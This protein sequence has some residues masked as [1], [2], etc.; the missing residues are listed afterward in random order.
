[1]DIKTKRKA[2]EQG[3]VAR[4]FDDVSK[5]SLINASMEKILG[6]RVQANDIYAIQALAKSN[7]RF[8]VS[9]AKKYQGRGVSLIDLIQDGNLGL[10][11][12]AE[13]FDPDQNVK[14]I[15]Y[16]VWW[17]RQS[18]LASLA[19]NSR[20]VR[21]PLNRSPDMARVSRAETDMR[22]ILGRAPTPMEISKKTEIEVDKVVQ[23][24]SMNLAEIRLDAPV[25]ESEDASLVDRFMSDDVVGVEKEVESSMLSDLINKA[26]GT[27]KGRDAKITALYFGLNGQR[28]HTLEEIGSE[29]NI[30]RER[31]RQI[32]DRAI[33]RL[34]EGEFSDALKSFLEGS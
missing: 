15:S 30:S 20:S 32:R 16:A 13:R 5:H 10:M 23:L 3:L 22:N 8:V 17:I 11:M 2:R 24:Q 25:A 21:I 12:A 34:R 31:V 1:M 6:E 26:L 27:L 19:Q 18:I 33:G 4:Y 14:F 28:P 9:V 29:M 7:L